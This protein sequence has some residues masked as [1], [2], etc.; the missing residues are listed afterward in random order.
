M[1]NLVKEFEELR[2]HG[3]F[4]S[5]PLNEFVAKLVADIEELKGAKAKAK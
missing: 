4:M 5:D 1:A 2:K 3:G